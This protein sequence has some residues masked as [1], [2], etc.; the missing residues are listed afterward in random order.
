VEVAAEGVRDAALAVRRIDPEDRRDLKCFAGLEYELLRTEPLYVPEL[1][2]DLRKRLRGRSAF[3]E[4]MQHAAFVASNGRDVARCVA[5]INGRWQR[6]SGEQAGFIGC[7]A[8]A[9]HADAEVGELLE[10]AERWLVQRGADR[11]IAPYNGTAFHGLGAQTDAFDEEPIFPFPWQPPHYPSLFEAA[12]YRPTYPFWVYDIAF[13]SEQYRSV[14]RRAVDHARCTVRSFDKKRWRAELDTMRGLFNDTFRTEWEFHA[15]TEGEFREV[16]D[17]FKPVLDPRQLL[18]AEVDGEPAGFCV[19]MPDW[20]PLFRSLKG[21]MGPLQVARL[22]LG[23][24]RYDRAGLLMIGVLES[25]RGKH[26]GQTLAATL[27]R[28]YQALGLPGAF[29]YVV[30]DHNLSSRRLAE[31]LGGHGRILHHVYDKPLPAPVPDP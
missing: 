26:I 21:R 15:A 29:Y 20:T 19:G 1:T 17:Q 27:Y 7:F 6:D 30:N 14:A 28:R 18:F 9:R 8:A 24:K 25:Q 4:E 22:L 2:S 16:F 23:A 13:A 3:Y 11:V 12:G 31:S 10:T 5:F